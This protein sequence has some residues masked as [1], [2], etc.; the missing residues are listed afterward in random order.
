LNPTPNFAPRSAS[1][2]LA[3]GRAG[4]PSFSQI[5]ASAAFFMAWFNFQDRGQVCREKA[6]FD[7]FVG[8]ED[9]QSVLAPL[10][11]GGGAEVELVAL[12]VERLGAG[13]MSGAAGNSSDWNKGSSGSSDAGTPRSTGQ[14]ASLSF[15]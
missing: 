5:G 13:G 3:S 7:V 4:A 1:F 6:I 2:A 10:A 12:A 8:G 9:W 14:T 15:H 11:Q